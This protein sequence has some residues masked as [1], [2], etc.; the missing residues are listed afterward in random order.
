MPGAAATAL[1]SNRT[2]PAI[3]AGWVFLCPFNSHASIEGIL[4]RLAEFY[5]NMH[6]DGA[7]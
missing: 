4:G 3:M 5:V 6:L 1:R 2:H 7:H